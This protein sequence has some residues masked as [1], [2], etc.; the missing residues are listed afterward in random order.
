MCSGLSLVLV[1]DALLSQV[2]SLLCWT[3]RCCRA[4]ARRLCCC[5]RRRRHNRGFCRDGCGC[6]VVNTV[7]LIVVVNVLV[8][9]GIIFVVVLVLRGRCCCHRRGRCGAARQRG[10]RE[11]R[12]V[13]LET[14]TVIVK[15]AKLA[16]WVGNC[17][18]VAIDGC[19]SGE[20][21][22]YVFAHRGDARMQTRSHKLQWNQYLTRRDECSGRFCGSWHHG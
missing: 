2:W 21:I 15:V 20:N 16:F 4:L 22:L 19:T 17:K 13:W 5:E 7:V 9:T 12:R 18:C 10:C 11:H 6:G 14:L 1:V 3:C 8:V